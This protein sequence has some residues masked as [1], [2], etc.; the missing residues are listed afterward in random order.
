M[1]GPRT[2]GRSSMVLGRRADQKGRIMEMLSLAVRI[3]GTA[4]Q[5]VP[6]CR[7]LT[8]EEASRTDPLAV[9][10]PAAGV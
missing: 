10:R 3:L 7:P 8:G 9:P 2:A 5:P 6:P 4:S 1:K